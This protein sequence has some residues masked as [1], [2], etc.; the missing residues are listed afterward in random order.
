MKRFLS[1]VLAFMLVT[2]FAACSKIEYIKLDATYISDNGEQIIFGLDGSFLYTW[3]NADGFVH[4]TYR[5]DGKKCVLTQDNGN[6]LFTCTKGT[7]DYFTSGKTIYR[8]VDD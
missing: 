2:V 3:S 8:L 4:G 1:I 7:D 6:P 5:F